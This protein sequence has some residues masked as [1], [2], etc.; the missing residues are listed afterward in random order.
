MIVLP[1]METQTPRPHNPKG[2]LSEHIRGD[3]LLAKY[4]RE[5]RINKEIGLSIPSQDRSGFMGW[6]A[7]L[8]RRPKQG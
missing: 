5:E 7:S 1:H 3:N 4:Q 2:E 8:L 6:L